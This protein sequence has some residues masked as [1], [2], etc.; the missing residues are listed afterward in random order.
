[1][2]KR[3]SR[4]S[5]RS[6]VYENANALYGT[7]GAFSSKLRCNDACECVCERAEH[8]THFVCT[9]SWMQRW[10]NR[11]AFMNLSLSIANNSREWA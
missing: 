7:G 11:L 1:M 9:L 6:P 5:D 2:R 4:T 10:E 8:D 3:V